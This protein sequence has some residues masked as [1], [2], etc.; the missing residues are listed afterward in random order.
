M[1]ESRNEGGTCKGWGWPLPVAAS[2]ER[3]GTSMDAVPFS[4]FPAS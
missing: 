3:L 4:V 1:G 2:W